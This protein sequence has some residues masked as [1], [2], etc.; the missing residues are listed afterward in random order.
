MLSTTNRAPASCAT[1]AIA[2]MSAMPSKGLVGVSTQTI[3]V[4]ER[5][6]ARTESTSATVAIE[7]ST[8]QGRKTWSKS[9]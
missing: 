1:A 8:P 5:I 4:L 2:S 3:R 6:A 7:W 9:R